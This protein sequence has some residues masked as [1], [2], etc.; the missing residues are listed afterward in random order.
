MTKQE[1]F[2]TVVE[3]LRA[4]GKKSHN[5]LY[6]VYRGPNGDRCAAGHLIPD[7]VYCREM[8]GLS[9]MDVVPDI[10][11]DMP[12]LISGLG[13]DL[14]LVSDLQVVHDSYSV[15]HWEEEWKRVAN[16]HGLVY[17]AGANNV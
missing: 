7:H 1:T 15:C 4:Q 13:Y 2:D 16:D 17:S 6:C 9:V 10:K 14:Q 8:E 12:A 11:V 3:K 5:G